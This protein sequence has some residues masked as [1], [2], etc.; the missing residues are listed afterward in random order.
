M[1]LLYLIAGN[2]W[3]HRLALG[4]WWIA[5]GYVL[6]F[7]AYVLSPALI[8]LL[9]SANIRRWFHSQAPAGARTDFVLLIPAHNEQPVLPALLASRS[10]LNYPS[11]RFQTVVVADNCTDQ[12]AALAREAGVICFERATGQPSNKSQALLYAAQSLGITP[13]HSDAV[14]CVLDADC[15]LDP[16]FLTELDRHFVQADAAPVVQCGRYVSNAFDSDVTVLDAAAEALRQYVA[17]GARR[18]LGLDS[19]IAG[20]GCCMR[21]HIFAQLMALPVTSLAEDKEWKAYL[22]EQR[23]RVAYCPAARLSYQAV[24]DGKAFRKQRKRWL[25]GYVASARTHGL[26]MLGQGLWRGSLSQVD[27]AFDLLQMPRSCLFLAAFVF[28]VA[29]GAEPW[30][31]VS[32][33]VWLGLAAGLLGYAALG[34]SLIGAAPRHFLALF[35]GARLVGGVA[36]S[37]FTIVMGRKAKVWDATR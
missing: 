5:Q 20:L 18:L 19:L 29:A 23:V 1:A 13:Q 21:E 34:L 3:V 7:L 2:E 9:F 10:R 16:Q 36:K 6:V 14:V 11:V 33:W 15:S 12:T 35:T 37:L 26:A 24:S 8:Y 30:A 25:S 27:F 31:L 32:S 22:T 28:G 17:A 4:A